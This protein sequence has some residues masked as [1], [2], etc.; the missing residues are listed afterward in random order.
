MKPTNILSYSEFGDGPPVILLHGLLGSRSNM[1]T[2][3]KSLSD[4]FR[5]FTL[6]LRNHG[7]SF[8]DATM[9]Y[10]AMVADLITFMDT[11]NIQAAAVAGHS[12][13]GKCA[14]QAALNFP[15]RISKLV[16]VDIAPKAYAPWWADAVKAMLAVDPA[17]VSKRADADHML[18]AAIP[19]WM[20]RQFLLQNLEFTADKKYR[21]RA[22]L[23]G[24]LTA[25]HDISAAVDGTP[26]TGETLFIKGGKSSYIED[27]DHVLIRRLFPRAQLKTIADAGHLAHI[28]ATEVFVKLLI[29]FLM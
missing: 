24:L 11:C 17:A 20:F 28:E 12:M 23:N 3:A 15:D 8:H 19:D 1:N 22:N 25:E 7:A 29:D 13:G 26:F 6:D 10:A 18:K 5:V 21:W 4:R 2:V 16:V 14:M 9:T 27:R